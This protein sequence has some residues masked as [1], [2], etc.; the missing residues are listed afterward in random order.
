MKNIRNILFLFLF[1]LYGA[2]YSQHSINT[3]LEG[4]TFTYFVG[5]LPNSTFEWNVSAG[6]NLIN[7]N[8][9]NIIINIPDSNATYT[10]SVIETS[11]FGCVG[12][13]RKII[14]NVTGC[15][16]YYIPNTFTVN[17][18]FL[19]ETFNIKGQNLY[20]DEFEMTI[21]NRWGQL[22]FS[23]NS[24]NTGWDGYYKNQICKQDVYT[25]KITFK[26]ESKYYSEI[27]QVNLL[28]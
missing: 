7:N 25:Y 23:T 10:I 18:D 14:I 26:K 15:F 17:N 13:E 24:V 20:V 1:T 4:N 9:N 22:L 11:E 5:G 3:C 8:G 21:Y 28:R 27:G 19:N 16:F 6:L 12:E 2:I